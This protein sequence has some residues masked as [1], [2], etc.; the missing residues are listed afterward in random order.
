MAL[1]RERQMQRTIAVVDKLGQ[2]LAI[3]TIA[4][5]ANGGPP[6]EYEFIVEARRLAHRDRIDRGRDGLSYLLSPP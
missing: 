3:Y 2:V 4:L 1:E 5:P 6:T